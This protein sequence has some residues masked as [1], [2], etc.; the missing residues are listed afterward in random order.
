MDSLCVGFSLHSISR[1]DKCFSD[2]L[3]VFSSCRLRL[4]VLTTCYAYCCD[5]CNYI[6][7]LYL[8][9]S[10]H[11]DCMY[12][13]YLFLQNQIF[14]HVFRRSSHYA[15]LPGKMCGFMAR[16]FEYKLP[17]VSVQTLNIFLYDHLQKDKYLSREALKFLSTSAHFACYQILKAWNK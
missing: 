15:K 4:Y 5:Y 13:L 12:Y 6:L 9:W 1:A 17:G 3:R 14:S 7:L 10:V 11:K 8:V 2:K 16:P